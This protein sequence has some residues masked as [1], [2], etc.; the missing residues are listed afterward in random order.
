MTSAISSLYVNIIRN[1]MGSPPD[2]TVLKAVCEFLIAIHPTEDTSRLHSPTR[3]YLAQH[4][5]DFGKSTPQE[6]DF[7]AFLFFYVRN[8]PDG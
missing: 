8:E 6:N 3:F 5:L 2:L 1:I 4:S 7:T